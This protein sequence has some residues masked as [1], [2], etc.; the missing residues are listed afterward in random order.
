MQHLEHNGLFVTNTR[1][2]ACSCIYWL[3]ADDYCGVLYEVT[4]YAMGKEFFLC[5]L[6]L[7]IPVPETTRSEACVCRRLLDGIAGSIPAADIDIFL[8]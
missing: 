8:L 2:D 6:R 4:Q 1:S 7:H 5:N 3:S